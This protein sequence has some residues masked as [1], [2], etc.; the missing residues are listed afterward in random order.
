MINSRQYGYIVLAGLLSATAT[1]TYAECKQITGMALA[2]AVDDTNLVAALKG[3]LGGG[4]RA[5]I[6]AQQETET[7]LILDMEHHFINDKGGLLHTKDKAVLTSVPGKVKTYMLEIGYNVIDASGYYAGYKG[8]FNSFGLIDLAAGK[9]VL[10][11][12]GEI[13][14]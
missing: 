14:K 3:E 5:R 6:T 1:P 11:Y 4:A 2:N 12:N 9:V 10:R 13:C 7:G 8:S